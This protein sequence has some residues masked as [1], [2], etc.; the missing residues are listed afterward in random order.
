MRK[1]WFKPVGLVYYPLSPMGWIIT[2]IT[3][4]LC[5]YFLMLLTTGRIP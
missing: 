3:I 5:V 2:L 4:Y 1:N